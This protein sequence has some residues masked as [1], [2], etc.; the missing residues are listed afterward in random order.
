MQPL[1]H[2]Y[3]QTSIHRGTQTEAGH[4][5]DPVCS[6]SIIYDSTQRLHLEIIRQWA[7]L[8]MQNRKKKK[9]SSHHF[10]THYLQSLHF[11]Y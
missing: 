7:D 8:K 2:M 5:F 10:S 4:A 1:I 11:L 6:L 9:N 3:T